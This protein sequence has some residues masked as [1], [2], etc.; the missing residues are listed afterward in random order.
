VPFLQALTLGEIEMIIDPPDDGMVDGALLFAAENTDS[1]KQI[2]ELILHDGRLAVI[3]SHG[4]HLVVEFMTKSKEPHFCIDFWS[5]SRESSITD[6]M[7]Q[8]RQL[9]QEFTGTG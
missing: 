5:E 7:E 6:T 4:D 3:R 2:R 9:A 8:A 1:R